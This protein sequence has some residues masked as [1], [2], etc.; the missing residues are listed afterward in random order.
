MARS[1]EFRPERQPVWPVALSLDR[2]LFPP[3][4]VSRLNSAAP[5]DAQA[6]PPMSRART[7]CARIEESALRIGFGIKGTSEGEAGRPQ[8]LALQPALDRREPIP[9]RPLGTGQLLRSNHG[10]PI[11]GR[12]RH[13]N[14]RLTATRGIMQ[15]DQADS[16]RWL[17]AR[18]GSRESTDALPSHQRKRGQETCPRSRENKLA[19]AANAARPRSI[20][21]RP[22]PCA[23]SPPG[24]DPA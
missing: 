14:V 24:P 4:R 8:L 6:G 16:A 21:A 17:H 13:V 20:S 15:R 3:A 22:K 11:A 18:R 2:F 1:F 10:R 7:R 12:L 19:T 5:Y 9:L 23:R